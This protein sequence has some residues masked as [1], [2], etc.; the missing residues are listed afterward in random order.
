MSLSEEF[1]TVDLI[2]NSHTETRGVDAFALALIK[3]E[4]QMRRLVTHLVY[5][6][7]AFGAGHK[8]ALREA[9][10]S[11]KKVY[12]AGLERGFDALYPKSVRDLIGSEYPQLSEWL[13]EARGYRNKI[14]HGQLTADGLTRAQLIRLADHI[15]RWCE[16]LS[17]GCCDEFGYDGFSNSFHK[18]K[19]GN[20]NARLRIK[21]NSVSDYKGFITNYMELKG[22]QN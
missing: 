22:K 19:V 13:C 2:L 14:F 15:R 1:S 6:S 10:E 11:S 3:A 18:S 4:K 12:F 5:Q 17:D 16:K 20:L 9:L 8:L 7:L 21:L